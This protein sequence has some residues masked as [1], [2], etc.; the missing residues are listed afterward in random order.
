MRWTSASLRVMK[1]RH[2]EV[3][4]VCCLPG[5]AD[6]HQHISAEGARDT[7]IPWL[8]FCSSIGHPDCWRR[9]HN[10]SP[11][12]GAA[13]QSACPGQSD[14]IV[15]GPDAEGRSSGARENR[16]VGSPYGRFALWSVR[17]TGRR[18]TDHKA[19][20][21]KANRPAPLSSASFVLSFSSSCSSSS[22]SLSPYFYLRCIS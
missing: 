14:A 3:S 10:R 12:T 2:G 21:N 19:N 7:A 18:R 6:G 16:K 11:R 17:L 4:G 5:S 9:A 1:L 22:S 20:R 15:L 13:R 8:P